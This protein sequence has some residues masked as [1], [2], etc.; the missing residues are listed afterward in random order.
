MQRARADAVWQGEDPDERAKDAAE[1]SRVGRNGDDRGAE[2][3]AESEYAGRDEV[4]WDTDECI[5]NP[6][7]VCLEIP[8]RETKMELYF[9]TSSYQEDCCVSFTPEGLS[10]LQIVGAVPEDYATDSEIL[11]DEAYWL[12]HDYEGPLKG[13]S[14]SRR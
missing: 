5:E 11:M 2:R 6:V 3:L 14:F 12:D 13:R 1:Y 9:E 7:F 4:D 10:V 8:W